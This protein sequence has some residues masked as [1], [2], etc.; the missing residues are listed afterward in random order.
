MRFP[1]S[2]MISFFGWSFH[3]HLD[4][5]VTEKVCRVLLNWVSQAQ[6]IWSVLFVLLLN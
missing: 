5:L 1:G 4:R 2:W 3:L 6:E